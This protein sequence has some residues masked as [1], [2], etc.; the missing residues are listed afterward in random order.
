MHIF[1]NDDQRTWLCYKPFFFKGLENELDSVLVS[2]EGI[3][4][5]LIHL[6]KASPSCWNTIFWKRMMLSLSPIEF[7]PLCSKKYKIQ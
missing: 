1:L 6:P 2:T 7:V 3:K 4:T 5:Y